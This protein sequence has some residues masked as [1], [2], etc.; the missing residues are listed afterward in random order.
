MICFVGW[1][2]RDIEYERNVMKNMKSFKILY[3]VGFLCGFLVDCHGMI[4]TDDQRGR[5]PVSQKGGLRHCCTDCTHQIFEDVTA[6]AVRYCDCLGSA[7]R[8]AACA[9]LINEDDQR[10]TIAASQCGLC[11]NRWHTGKLLRDVNLH[12]AI[13]NMDAV[14]ITLAMMAIRDTDDRD[15]LNSVINDLTPL[16]RGIKAYA[17]RSVDK[18]RTENAIMAFMKRLVQEGA[19]LERRDGYGKLPLDYLDQYGYLEAARLVRDKE[20]GAFVLSSSIE[21]QCGQSS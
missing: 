17:D 8:H 12:N 11:R 19:L 14:A 6:T 9:L 10:I 15:S 20:L 13:K 5:S 16:T 18:F 4:L 21:F 2:Q 3:L 7:Y 1:W